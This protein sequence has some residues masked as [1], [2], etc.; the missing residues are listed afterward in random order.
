MNIPRSDHD[1]YLAIERAIKMAEQDVAAAAKF[2]AGKGVPYETTTRV[3]FSQER[4]QPQ[5]GSQP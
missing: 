5:K 2:L 1:T 4:R 3:L